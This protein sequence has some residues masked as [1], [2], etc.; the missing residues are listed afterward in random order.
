MVAPPKR[1][2]VTPQ[3][4]LEFERKAETKHE[5]EQ[6]EIV[7]MTGASTSHN[8]ITFNLTRLI[9]NQLE[10]N[11]CEGFAQDMRV[12]IQAHHRYYY[13]DLM[14]VCS[15]PQFEDDE[16]DTLLNP[17]LIIE[18]LSESTELRDRKQ[19]FKGY[20]TIESLT[21]YLLISQTEPWIEHWTRL[22]DGTGWRY[23][24]A[25]GLEAILDLPCI[26]CQLELA[27]LYVHVQFAPPAPEPSTN[28]TASETGNSTEN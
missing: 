24:V 7:A 15:E 17:T 16:L 22:T 20:W 4:Y 28:E 21:D 25:T 12:R 5:Y 1:R 8:R 9:G 26:G 11:S 27:H 10:G 18:V 19:K 6:G 14:V 23:L 2:Y 3:E 13:P